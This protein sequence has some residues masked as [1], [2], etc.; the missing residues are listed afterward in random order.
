M[1]SKQAARMRRLPGV[2]NLPSFVVIPLA[3]GPFGSRKRDKRCRKSE[4]V[5]MFNGRIARFD[6][7]LHF[8][9]RIRES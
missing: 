2:E 6:Q 9:G 7:W 5:E 8:F 1:G 4:N 3:R